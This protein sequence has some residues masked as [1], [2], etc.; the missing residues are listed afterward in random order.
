[1]LIGARPYHQVVVEK[2]IDFLDY[3]LPEEWSSTSGRR[4]DTF[5]AEIHQL[6]QKLSQ[7]PTRPTRIVRK[8][9]KLLEPL[10]EQQKIMDM[11]G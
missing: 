11:S 9:S 6:E 10:T 7:A 3:H 1:M 2:I 5:Y 8:P 4:V